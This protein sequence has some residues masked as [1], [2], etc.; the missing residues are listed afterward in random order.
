MSFVIQRGLG[1]GAPYLSEKLGRDY[2]APG[3]GWTLE[4]RDATAYPTRDAADARLAALPKFL[5]DECVVTA[6][7][8]VPPPAS[9]HHTTLGVPGDATAGDITAAY[10]RLAMKH[11]PDRGGSEEAFKR[12]KC[13]YEALVGAQ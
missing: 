10:R 13:A 4:Q 12:V 9:E 3:G 7:T 11:H 8:S 1:P 5:A 6:C 2:G